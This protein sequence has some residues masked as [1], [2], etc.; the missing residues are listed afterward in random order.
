MER[1]DAAHE[2]RYGYRDPEGEVE[3]VHIGLGMV[4]PGPRPRPPAAAVG[5][6]SESGRSARF[7]GEWLGARVLRGEPPAG[8]RAEGPTIF[9][10]PESTLV[11]PSGW[12]AEVDDAGTIVARRSAS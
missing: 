11:L 5:T 9:E 4:V 3:L 8:V 10:L 6:L 1:F 12:R 7:G 2:E